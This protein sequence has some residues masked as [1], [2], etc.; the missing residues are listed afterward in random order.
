MITDVFRNSLTARPDRSRSARR[1]GRTHD[2]P[3][4]RRA[5]RRIPDGAS[6]KG[7]TATE[8]VAFARVMREKAEPFWDGEALPVLDTCGTGGD[9]SGHVQYFDRGRVCC[10]RRR[11]SR[12][13]AWQP[14][15]HEPLRKRRCDG[16]SRRRNPDADRDVCARPSR[17]SASDFSSPSAFISSM[18]H[19]M[20]ARTQLKIRTVFNISGRWR[21]R[22]APRSR[23]L[24]VFSPDM[25]ELMA[26]ALART[27]VDHAFVVHGHDGLDEIS[28]SAP[29]NVLEIRDGEIAIQRISPES[30]GVTPARS[31]ALRGGDARATRRSSKAILQR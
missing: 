21:I 1:H 13:Q 15:R 5:D 19:V 14:V 31:E 9:R 12:R 25:M 30:F 16:S 2:R 17:K 6:M 8:L 22:L 18:K 27:G 11:S 23:S 26:N 24:G 29:T 4:H 20:P 3:G 10:G 28:I 7:E